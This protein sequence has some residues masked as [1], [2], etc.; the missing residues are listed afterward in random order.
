[1][2]KQFME[3]EAGWN[4]H[5]I[6]AGRKVRELTEPGSRMVVDRAEDA[7]IY[8]CDRPGWVNHP[9]DLTEKA[10][11]SEIANGA[12]YLLLTLYKMDGDRFTGYRFDDPDSPM[13]SPCAKWVRA[14]CPVIH[15]GS[16]YE[17]IDLQPGK[18]G[19]T[20]GSSSEKRLRG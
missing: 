8:Y 20:A 17:I 4:A 13:G 18:H 11:R 19:R 6:Q 10:I 12:D 2:R 15:D 5:W 1:M 3:V 9:Q 16:T 14:N 7:L